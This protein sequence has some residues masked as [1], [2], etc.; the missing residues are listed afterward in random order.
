MKKLFIIYLL[1]SPFVLVAQNKNTEKVSF[2]V[3]GNCEIC[4]KRIEKSALTVKGVKAANWDIPS[5]LISIV[6]NPNRVTLLKIQNSIAQV[7][8]DTPLAKAPDEIYNEL[9]ICC[10]Y[11][12][13]IQ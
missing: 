2:E 7:G 12:R 1:I 5:S 13:T 8:H 3:T 4:K 6:Y 10:I 9:P 11:R